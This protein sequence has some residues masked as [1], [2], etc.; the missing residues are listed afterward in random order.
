MTI[1]QYIENISNNFKNGIATPRVILVERAIVINEEIITR[2]SEK[3]KL[4]FINE[5]E[6]NRKGEVC[7]ATSEEVRPE[8]K[9]VFTSID[10]LNYIYAVLYGSSNQNKFEEYLNTDMKEIPITADSTIF[11][12]LVK[13]GSELRKIHQ[14]ENSFADIN[15]ALPESEKV[16]K[17]INKILVEI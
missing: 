2:I 4:G 9:I 5:K 11:W 7:F 6:I 14:L 8:F 15:A 10:A 3:L 13:L 1:S 16:I 12:Q 17:E